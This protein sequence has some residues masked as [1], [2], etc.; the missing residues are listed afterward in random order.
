MPT[1]GHITITQLIL[2]ILIFS[3]M[4]ILI[5]LTNQPT[6]LSLSCR[7]GGVFGWKDGTIPF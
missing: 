3:C 4:V 1:E 6:M 5:L 2:K 7:G